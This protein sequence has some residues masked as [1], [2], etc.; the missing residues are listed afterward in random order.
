MSLDEKR[1]IR[2]LRGYAIA[3]A[4]TFLSTAWFTYS[5]GSIGQLSFPVGVLVTLSMLV[6]LLVLIPRYRWS[7]AITALVVLAALPLGVRL[8]Q[9]A[10]RLD[11]DHR[12]RPRYELLV[13]RI[14]RGEIPVGDRPT[15]IAIPDELKNLAH[16][17]HA[18]RNPSGVLTVEFW[19]GEHNAFIYRSSGTWERDFWSHWSATPLEGK[20]VWGYD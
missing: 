9:A 15:T 13:G 6:A 8:G 2:V 17:V 16:A 20:W 3:A 14:E 4:L 11:F 5:R 18:W 10:L 12:L 7:S 19:W 1:P